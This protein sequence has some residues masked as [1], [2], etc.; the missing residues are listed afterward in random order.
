MYRRISILSNETH[1]VPWHT[2]EQEGMN[3]G[4]L[5][6][7]TVVEL[8]MWLES[9]WELN[10]IIVQGK[11]V[12]NHSTALLLFH[13]TWQCYSH[14]TTLRLGF[15]D[16][17]VH[18]SPENYNTYRP[19]SIMSLPLEGNQQQALRLARPLSGRMWS[20]TP[21]RPSNRLSGCRL[22]ATRPTGSLCKRKQGEKSSTKYRT[23][24]KTYTNDI[25]IILFKLLPQT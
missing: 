1:W 12:A 23:L 3:C 17:H 20:S 7:I 16:N 18:I 9:L 4:W 22:S 11:G 6:W 21:E 19:S 8:E 2:N 14:H 10:A 5:H 24:I 15:I 25:K 13:S